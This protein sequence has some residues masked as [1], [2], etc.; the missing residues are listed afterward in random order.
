MSILLQRMGLLSSS[1]DVAVDGSILLAGDQQSGADVLLLSGDQQQTGFNAILRQSDPDF[2]SVTLLVEPDGPHGAT[3]FSDL[4]TTGHTLTRNGDTVQDAVI[5]NFGVASM[6]FDGVGDYI[7]CGIST[8]HNFG[9]GD[10]TVEFWTRMTAEPAGIGDWIGKWESVASGRQWLVQYQPSPNVIVFWVSTDGTN[11]FNAEF[12]FDIETMNV[13]DFF[14]SNWHHIAA[15]MSSNTMRVFVDGVIGGV[16]VS[17]VGTLF[18]NS[19]VGT[20]I[21]AR[22]AGAGATSHIDAHIA[23]LRITKGVA[24]YTANFTPPTTEF[25]RS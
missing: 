2:A 5:K 6:D 22:K 20:Y 25:N 24:R 13:G 19:T 16:T 9:S 14:D 21:G 11:G 12:D 23:G 15:T 17:S 4:S 18:N 3:T 1:G 7:D 10:F 8:E